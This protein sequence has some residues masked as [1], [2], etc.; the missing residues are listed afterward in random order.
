MGLKQKAVSGVKWNMVTT[1]YCTLLQLLRLSVLTYLLEKSDF[2]IIALAMMVISFTDIFSE[3]GITVAVIHKQDITP[4]QYSSVYW[5]NIVLHVVVFLLLWMLSPAISAFYKEPI[6]KEV[7]PLLGIQILLNAFGKMFQTI[8]T[9]ELQFGFISKVRMIS[10]TIG[11]GV[12]VFLAW[13][14]LGVFSLVYGQLVQVAVNQ[15]VYAFEGLGKQKI[16]LHFKFNEI[17]D[18]L[19]IGAYQLG[20]QVMDF[21]SAK[22]DVLLIGRFFGMDDLGIYNIAKDLMLKPYHII[23]S[24][25]SNVA[26]SAFAR[27]QNNLQAI[28]ENYKRVVKI[29]SMLCIFIYFAMF[30][31]ADTITAILYAP[32]FASVATFLRVF[33]VIGIISSINGQASILQ[34]ALGRTDIGFK[35]TLIRVVCSV[36]VILLS[37]FF[38]IYTVVYAQMALTIVFFF[39]YW[40]LVVYPLSTIRFGEYLEI[41]KESLLVSLVISVPFFIILTVCSIPLWGQIA[42]GCL[43]ALLYAAYYWFHRRAFVNEL[44][45]LVLNKRTI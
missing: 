30:V 22:I 19:R 21:L 11:F 32:E 20:A 2:G 34:I 25:V 23:S 10:V 37:S 1:I 3:L 9:K 39:V 36:A 38:T 12:T 5:M 29:I 40:R 14:G 17:R 18:F 42:L 8:K 45:Q 35:W 26:S 41:F 31:F 7:I 28:K 13:K 33:V 24:L 44:L 27:I 16:T 6:L 4:D 15:G 43:F